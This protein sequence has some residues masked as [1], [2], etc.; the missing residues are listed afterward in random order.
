MKIPSPGLMIKRTI[1]LSDL[2]FDRIADP[3]QEHPVKD[4]VLEITLQKRMIELMRENDSPPEQHERLG[5]KV[6]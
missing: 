6:D 3:L 2:L 5:L 1:P 4:P